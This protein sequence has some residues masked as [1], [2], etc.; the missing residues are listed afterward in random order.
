MQNNHSERNSRLRKCAEEVIRSKGIKR[1]E[2][3]PYQV[4]VNLNLT[5]LEI[6]EILKEVWTLDLDPYSK[7][8]EKWM[9]GEN[10]FNPSPSSDSGWASP[11]EMLYRDMRVHPYKSFSI[12][13]QSQIELWNVTYKILPS[14]MHPCDT[15][16]SLCPSVVT[17]RTRYFARVRTGSSFEY[18]EI[19]V[20]ESHELRKRKTVMGAISSN[21]I[22]EL[23]ELGRFE[24]KEE[25]MDLIKL[26]GRNI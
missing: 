25:E 26:I 5:A 7:Q 2:D 6:E 4:L 22:A 15:V 21:Q 19:D 14:R 24:V 12:F 13:V 10:E 3:L 16:F 17:S 1:Y 18:E 9:A 23:M 8:V 11:K 20:S